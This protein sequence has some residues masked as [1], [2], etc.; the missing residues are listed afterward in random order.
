[1]KLKITAIVATIALSLV[2]AVPTYSAESK[3]KKAT[4]KQ[5][6]KSN[7]WTTLSF[8]GSDYVKS[9]G[10]RSIYCLQSNIIIPSKNKPTVIKVRFAR[11][12][13]KSRLDTTATNTYIFGSGYPKSK[14]YGSQCWAIETKYP[15]VAQIKVSGKASRYY[16]DMRQ[17]KVWTPGANYPE[18]MPIQVIS[19]SPISSPTP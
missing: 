19:P 12:V 18:D 5:T 7:V 2:T 14:W 4:Y 15:V 6:I 17:L 9:N 1:M 3:G 13:G 11:V 8:S 16:S 10:N